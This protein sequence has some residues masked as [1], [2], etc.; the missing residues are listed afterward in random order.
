MYALMEALP[1]NSLNSDL[2]SYVINSD[3]LHCH[4]HC[5]DTHTHKLY[6]TIIYNVTLCVDLTL[7]TPTKIFSFVTFLNKTK[8]DYL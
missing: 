2:K 1:P 3:L 7:I 8:K 6:L 4:T 5:I